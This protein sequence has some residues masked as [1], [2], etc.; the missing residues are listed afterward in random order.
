MLTIILNKQEV[1][2]EMR[3]F[4]WVCSR[5]GLCYD[6]KHCLEIKKVD[7]IH[8]YMKCNICINKKSFQFSVAVFRF[9]LRLNTELRL[10]RARADEPN[11]SGFVVQ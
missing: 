11:L 2:I 6:A 3:L 4:V 1:L 7:G 8:L 10:K 5:H 9:E